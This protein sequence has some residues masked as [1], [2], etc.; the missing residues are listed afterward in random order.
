MTQTPEKESF[1][2]RIW[3]YVVGVVTILLIVGGLIAWGW[4][5]THPP[6]LTD[7]EKRVQKLEKENAEL[8]KAQADQKKDIQ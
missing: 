2:T 7:L 4:S 6:A 8:K 5:E 3:R 1:F